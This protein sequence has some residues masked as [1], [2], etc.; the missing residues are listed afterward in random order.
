MS[1]V[2]IVESI[3]DATD[4]SIKMLKEIAS[5]EMIITDYIAIGVTPIVNEDELIRKVEDVDAIIVRWAS[6]SRK[7]LEN[8]RK[9]KVIVVHGTNFD[10]VDVKDATKRGVLVSFI[11]AGL[12][13]EVSEHTF[14]LILALLKKIIKGDKYL[15][16]GAPYRIMMEPKLLPTN[17]ESKT[18]GV[19]GIGNIGLRVAKLGKAFEMKVLAHDPYVTQDRA[20]TVGA[21][22]VD[23]QTLLKESDVVTIHCTLT[24]PFEKHPN[25]HLIGEKELKSMKRTAFI[26]NTARGPIIDQKALYR[27]LREEW[28]AGAAL[29]VFEEEPPDP[30]DP[31]FELQNVV[32]TPHI[33]G[34]SDESVTGLGLK[35]A[36]EVLA[37]LEGN[38]PENLVNP[39]VLKASESSKL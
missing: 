9:L 5:V 14:A 34:Y 38:I 25:Y 37:A 8:V 15:R 26:V 16:A 35:I 32:V 23:L 19:I 24:A 11:P 39:E 17:L 30:N 18:L 3:W 10:N 21:K 20:D 28:I 22:L 31:I 6:I 2:L 36:K 1:K 13:N 12:G 7:V 4:E 29:D 33:A 27:A